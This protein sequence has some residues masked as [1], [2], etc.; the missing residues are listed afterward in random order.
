MNYANSIVLCLRFY[1]VTVLR[2]SSPVD[3][4][5]VSSQQLRWARAVIGSRELQWCST[6]MRQRLVRRR[7]V[8]SR[9]RD[10]I[11]QRC[12]RWDRE[13]EG[14]PLRGLQSSLLL[15][16]VYFS[17]Y[18]CG[19]YDDYIPSSRSGQVLSVTEWRKMSATLLDS[20]ALVEMALGHSK[21]RGMR[22]CT[23]DLWY[24]SSNKRKKIK[25]MPC[26]TF[27]ERQW[28]LHQIQ[29]S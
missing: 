1:L 19:G 20:T 10:L 25:M 17:G 27:R 6:V 16:R 5:G 9:G 8:N 13:V 12:S 11:N 29:G 23:V 26:I 3:K 22:E 7:T 18:A 4:G 24:Y 21:R 15:F 14:G 2:S 28:R